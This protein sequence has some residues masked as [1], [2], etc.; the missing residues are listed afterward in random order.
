MQQKEVCG[1]PVYL[2]TDWAATLDSVKKLADLNPEIVIP[3]H[4]AAMQGTELKDGLDKLLANWNDVA[5]PE[6]GKWVET[7]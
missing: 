7:Q 5:V 1:P 6:H 3:G 2:T 4:G